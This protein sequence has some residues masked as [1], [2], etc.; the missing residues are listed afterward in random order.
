MTKT[1]KTFYLGAAL[2]AFALGTFVAMY[3]AS[4]DSQRERL[5]TDLEGGPKEPTGEADM[6]GDLLVVLDDPQPCSRSSGLLGLSRHL[7]HPGPPFTGYRHDIPTV[8][9]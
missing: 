5:R 7:A 6:V 1:S 2:A 3:P 9:E 8:Q 4:A